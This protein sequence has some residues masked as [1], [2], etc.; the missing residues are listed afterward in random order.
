VQPSVLQGRRFRAGEHFAGIGNAERVEGGSQFSEAIDFVRS[1]HG[2]QEVA[3][4]DA[5][6]MLTGYRA[7]HLDAHVQNSARQFFGPLESAG[8]AAVKQD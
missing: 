5:N 2:G 7:T 1:E 4:F 8:L 6:A 3:F